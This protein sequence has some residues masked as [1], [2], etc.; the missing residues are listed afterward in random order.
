MIVAM[1]SSDQVWVSSFFFIFIYLFNNI[2]S[3]SSTLNPH[4]NTERER[5][6][7]KGAEPAS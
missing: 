3:L 1:N 2:H 5:K 6:E 7:C 4:Q